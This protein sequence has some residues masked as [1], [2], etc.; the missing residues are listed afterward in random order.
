MAWRFQASKF[1]NTTPKIPKK[2][3]TIFDLPTGNLCCTN[4]GIQANQ[5]YLAFAIEGE[6]GKLGILPVGAKGRRLRKDIG[7]ICAHGDLIDDFTFM[8][9]DNDTLVTC[10]RDD[11]LKVWKISASEEPIQSELACEIDVG[12]GVMLDSLAPHTTASGLVAASSSGSSYL[13]DLEEKKVVQELGGVID[14]GVSLSW[15]PDGRLLAVSCDRGRQG[16]IYDARAG[17]DPIKTMSLHQGMGREGRILFC[18]DRLLSSGF[19]NKRVQEVLIYETNKWDS[20]VHTQEFVSTTGVL[21]PHYDEDTKLVYLA[22]K[23]TNK[24]FLM[25]MQ[26]RQPLLSSV[27]ETTFAEQTLGSC[28]GSKRS[29]NVMVGEVDTFYQLTKTS[30]LSVPCIVPR[31]SYREFHADLFPDTM[32]NEAGCSSK[33]WLNGSDKMPAKVSLSPVGNPSPPPQ[34]PTPPKQEQRV[35]PAPRSVATEVQ[36]PKPI[37]TVKPAVKEIVYPEPSAPHTAQK[38][39]V[40]IK[41]EDS[42]KE[43]EKPMSTPIAEPAVVRLRTSPPSAGGSRPLSSRERPKSCVVGLVRSKFRY[44]ETIVGIKAN[45]SVFSNLRNVNT[46]LPPECNGACAGGQF[47]AVPLSGPAGV[48]G[49]YNIDEPCKLPDGVM[50]GIFNKAP[51]T[52]LKWNPFDDGELACGTDAGVI[53]IWNFSKTDGARNEMEPSKVISIGGEKVSCLAWHP[54][55]SGL[56]AVALAD[57]SIELWDVKNCV[58]KLKVCSHTGSILSITWSADGRFLASLGKDLMLNVHQPQLGEDCLIR[59]KK[60]LENARAARVLYACDDRAII[61]VGFTKSSTRQ[62]YLLDSQS[63]SQIHVEIIDTATQPLIPHYDYDTNVLFLSGKGDQTLRMFE[64]CYDSPYFLSLTDYK[65]DSGCQSIAFHNKKVCDVMAVE[66]QRGWRL[67]EKS[68]ELMI[69]RV[70]RVKK[71]GFQTDLFPD[72]LVT[73]EPTLTMD[74]WFDGDERAPMFRSLKPNGVASINSAP[75]VLTQLAKR[76]N[77][78]DTTDKKVEETEVKKQVESSWSDQIVKDGT[79]EQDKMEGVAEEEWH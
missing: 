52:D 73:W 8:P 38:K 13:I 36:E 27:Y 53:N 26:E 35:A 65:G 5:N 20:P 40:Q 74:E 14:K 28:L 70:P 12:N 42:A 77:I 58:K 79:L 22:G 62:V 57:A 7:I 11:K 63:L 55:V 16:C 23:G 51:V 69:F 10:S 18:G 76:S 29:T 68:L 48:V 39:T 30:I 1:K 2:E 34:E 25:E 49:I 45:N 71:D 21:I 31:R 47:V 67:S 46:R 72:A 66:F 54:M 41:T 33:D 37:A 44:V 64:V 15:S 24:L 61:V 19:T 17:S 9:F 59:Q 50:D 78:P 4:N 60:M 32:G 6:G 56:L 75:P 43:N 3:D